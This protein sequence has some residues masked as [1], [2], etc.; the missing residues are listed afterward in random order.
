[1]SNGPTEADLKQ[2][3]DDFFL[4]FPRGGF[5]AADFEFGQKEQVRGRNPQTPIASTYDRGLYYFLDAAACVLYVGVATKTFGSRFWPHFGETLNLQPGNE[6]QQAESFQPVL[7]RDP[8]PEKLGYLAA[9][10]AFL[11]ATLRPRL[12]ECVGGA[13][14]APLA[15][16]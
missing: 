4:A 1:M 2:R 7:L 15:Q 5:S 12:N 3:I 10:E 14:L 16:P 6:W 9:L 13:P 11:I 8:T